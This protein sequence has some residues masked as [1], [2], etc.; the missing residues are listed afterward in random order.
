M[1]IAGDVLD[2]PGVVS[3]MPAGGSV[4]DVASLNGV[5][6]QRGTAAYTSSKLG[7][8]GLTKAAALDL[9]PRGIR[10]PPDRR[11]PDPPPLADLT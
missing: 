7:V 2:G 10:L 1:V 6:A 3:H 9:G 11:R 4:V 5:A 8:R